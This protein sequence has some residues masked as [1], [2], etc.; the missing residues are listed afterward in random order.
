MLDFTLSHEVK[1]TDLITSFSVL[2]AASTLVYTWTKDRH[3]RAKE[4]ADRIR[5]AAALTLSK[6]D[7]CQSLFASITD[8]IQPEVTEIDGFLI[9]TKDSI[10]ARDRFWKAAHEVRQK[11]LQTYY[12]EEIELA[13]APLLVYRKTV[14]DLFNSALRSAR[15]LETASFVILQEKC[16]AVILGV[17]VDSLQ[18][19]VLGNLL[20][21]AISLHALEY[22]NQ[23]VNAFNDVRAFLKAIVAATDRDLLREKASQPIISAPHDKGQLDFWLS[24]WKDRA[25]TS[26]LLA[27]LATAEAGQTDAFQNLLGP[28]PEGP[29]RDPGRLAATATCESI[30]ST[31]RA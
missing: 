31:R 19:A 20:R 10:L 30:Y 9:T 8:A 26:L 22:S 11:I 29:S 7:R 15:V 12:D 24:E 13:Y 25:V 6:V 28:V 2:C 1:I 4:Y 23:L 18:S 14:Y 5:S 27:K 16:Q 21:H 17:N 3:L